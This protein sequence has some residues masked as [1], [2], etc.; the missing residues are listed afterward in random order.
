MKKVAILMLTLCL[1]TSCSS[2]TP[3]YESSTSDALG[4]AASNTA[5]GFNLFGGTSN[6]ESVQ[7]S[8]IGPE[9]DN[10]GS[11]A[12]SDY[13]TDSGD[14]ASEFDSKTKLVYSAYYDIETMEYEESISSLKSSIE[15]YN[16]FFEQENYND[17]TPWDVYY[18]VNDNIYRYTGDRHY[19]CIIRVPVENYKSLVDAIGSIGHIT[20]QE[21]ELENITKKYNDTQSSI[22]NY[23]TQLDR[24]NEMY[25]EAKDI[26][27]MLN[28]QSKVFE[29]QD[30]LRTLYNDKD[31]MDT[32]VAYSKISIDIREVNEI[33]NG[34]DAIEHMKFLER[35]Q[36]S[37][38]S[39]LENA[40]ESVS[41]VFFFI[42]SNIIQI[43]AVILV[44]V[45][46]IKLKKS[47]RLS[48]KIR[49]RKP[50]DKQD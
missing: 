28:I 14:N 9:I 38:N 48:F 29:V 44:I 39:S 26:E 36:Y 16:G 23:E 25:K 10:L 12:E 49:L 41:N 1:L 34:K 27:D 46:V 17:S 7:D 42:A 4:V 40:I 50:K 15:K 20:S 47:K 43:G 35:L 19:R 11:N 22:E 32:D 5:G 31:S 45:G 37:L 21:S 3:K 6:S 13:T 18:G 33:S 8:T 24:L 2:N 30:R